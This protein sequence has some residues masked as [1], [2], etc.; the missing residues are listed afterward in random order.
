MKTEKEYDLMK[1]LMS[2]NFGAALALLSV[3]IFCGFTKINDIETAIIEKDFKKACTELSLPQW[4]S[5]PRTPKDNP[6]LERFNRTIQ[7]EFV[8]DIS[9]FNPPATAHSEAAH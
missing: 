9:E 6:V 2:R 1:I 4:Y 7:E 5:R 8:E 3:F